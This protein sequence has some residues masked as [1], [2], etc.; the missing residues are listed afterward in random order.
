MAL[1]PPPRFQAAKERHAALVAS[2]L[3]FYDRAKE[4][5]K[6]LAA[7]ICA[8]INDDMVDDELVQLYMSA[9]SASVD[10]CSTLTALNAELVAFLLESPYRHAEHVPSEVVVEITPEFDY[11]EMLTYEPIED[12]GNALVAIRHAFEHCVR[13]EYNMRKT[14]SLDVRAQFQL[15]TDLGDS[16]ACVASLFCA[17]T[18]SDADKFMLDDV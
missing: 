3:G 8:S 12:V 17:A 18:W 4:E 11:S 5:L 2:F 15:A 14:D 9:A 7:R 1:A 6:K 10:L 13:A 16:S